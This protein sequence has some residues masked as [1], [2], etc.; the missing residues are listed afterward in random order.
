VVVNAEERAE[1]PAEVSSFRVLTENL[2]KREGKE[3]GW[4]ISLQH[5][6]CN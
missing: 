6:Y 3:G 5:V 2:L 4:F 1:F